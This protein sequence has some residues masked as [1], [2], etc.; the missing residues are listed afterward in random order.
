M[1]TPAVHVDP[2]HLL[3]LAA[4][5]HRTAAAT[6]DVAGAGRAAAV[7]GPALGPIGGAFAAVFGTAVGRHCGSLDA[8]AEVI[9]T[10]GARVGS[11]A[12]AYTEGDDATAADLRG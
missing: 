7:V 8:L 12:H 4:S 6:A 10:V 9:D 2:E 3:T 5:L 11:A 1:I